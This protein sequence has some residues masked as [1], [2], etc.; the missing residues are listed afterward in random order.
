MRDVFGVVSAIVMYMSVVCWVS[1]ERVGPHRG[2]FSLRPSLP[3]MYPGGLQSMC[4]CQDRA[5]DARYPVVI[6]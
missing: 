2:L 4:S 6:F 3:S 5:F 1:F